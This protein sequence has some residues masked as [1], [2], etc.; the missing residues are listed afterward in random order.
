LGRALAILIYL[1][2][3]ALI[4]IG[5]R[6]V[7]STD[8]LERARATARAESLEQP[9]RTARIVSGDARVTSGAQG[10]ATLLLNELFAPSTQRS[11]QRVDVR[12]RLATSNRISTTGGIER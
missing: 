11:A 1:L 10:A 3:P 8:Y 7:A 6:A 9:F 2:S 5:G 4:V 12:Q